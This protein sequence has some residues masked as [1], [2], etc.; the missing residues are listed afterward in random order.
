[1]DGR[2]MTTRNLKT[3]MSLVVVSAMLAFSSGALADDVW[4]RHLKVLGNKG[5]ADALYRVG[6]Y[7]IQRGLNEV[8]IKWYVAAAEKGHVQAEMELADMYLQG[9]VVTQSNDRAIYWYQKA[10]ENGDM[11]GQFRLGMMYLNGEYVKKDLVQAYRW[12]R[13]AGAQGNIK[14]AEQL[15]DIENDMSQDQ[16]D[17]AETLVAG[18]H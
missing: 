15:V 3:I 1:M 6:R 13:L 9:K 18:K 4:L 11:N 17:A 5:D 14:A 7:D 2:Y 16:I 8:G 10:A 12:L